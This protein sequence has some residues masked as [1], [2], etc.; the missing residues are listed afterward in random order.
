M[1]A[2]KQELF[3][4]T[5]EN[6]FLSAEAPPPR[7]APG[8]LSRPGPGAVGGG[9]GFGAGRGAAAAAGGPAGTANLRDPFAR[10]DAADAGGAA[11]R[12]PVRGPPEHRDNYAYEDIVR[13]SAG[14]APYDLHLTRDRPTTSARCKY[15][16]A[17]RPC[18]PAIPRRP[19]WRSPGPGR[20]RL[21]H[22][23]IMKGPPAARPQR[24]GMRTAYP[25][26]LILSPTRELSMQ[27]HEEAR[28]FSYQTGVRVVVAYG[29]AP[30]TQQLRDLERGVDI[31]VATPGRLVD[32]LERAR[33]SLQ[34]IRY[35][36]LDEADRMLDMGFE[37][38]VR[39][40]VE[41]MDMP[42]PG[43]RQTMLFSATFP[44][45]IQRMASDFLENYI[46][47]AVG[48][49]GSS[50]EL[51]VQRIEFVQE[52]D[53]R[54]HLMDLLHAQRDTGK[55]T[56]TLVFVETKRGADSLESWLCMNGFPATSIHGD[57]NQQERE[58]ALRT[59]KSGKTPILVAT[60]VAARGLDIPHVAHVVNFDLPNDIDDYVHR[61]GR[62][63]RAGKSGLATAF[64]NENNS[65]MARPLAE[66][67]Q[68]SNQ[69]VPAWLSRYAARP[70]YGGGGGRN[71]RSGGGN[72]FG[73]R[74]F[75]NDSSS[76]G[77][78]GGRGGGD[79]YGGGSSGGY[80][81]S[82]SYGGGGYGGAG[83]PSAWD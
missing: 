2:K 56:L 70:S 28:K 44:K 37:P 57:R 31:L 41:Q 66:L 6:E 43:A 48:R 27:I 80:G 79:Y 33:V 75:R 39:R 20:G 42:P 40:I 71:R 34:S 5:E 63:G 78:G 52:A 3:N 51:I 82:S 38:Q 46:F 74:D 14:G 68:E 58:Y 18:S 50:T 32:L 81:G 77:K 60:D 23:G 17:P 8:L 24:G 12:G 83:A 22:S 19:S 69:E 54:S 59:F 64:F 65:N 76:F 72:R 1:T 4:F 47:L 9:S 16:Q 29:G 13:P 67:M 49:V 62:T 35:L 55:Q 53:K 25:L 30:I 61:I 11:D 15:V 45:E 26:A 10:V 21:P 7:A 73:G 36:A